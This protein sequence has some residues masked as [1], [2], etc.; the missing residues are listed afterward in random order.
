ML[1]TNLKANTEKSTRLK[2]LIEDLGQAAEKEDVTEITQYD[3]T[4]SDAMVEAAKPVKFKKWTKDSSKRPE[5]YD[6]NYIEIVP[7][8]S[9]QELVISQIKAAEKEQM[10][11]WRQLEL[12]AS[13]LNKELERV[14]VEGGESLKV[15]GLIK[16]LEEKQKQQYLSWQK[17]NKDLKK[18]LDE[19]IRRDQE[20]KKHYERV[21]K[22]HLAKSTNMLTFAQQEQKN[23]IKEQLTLL[24]KS[25]DIAQRNHDQETVKQISLSILRVEEGLRTLEGGKSAVPVSETVEER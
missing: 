2:H 20:M 11:V 3:T 14:K 1:Q 21:E 8:L 25:L 5:Q 23:E 24:S 4:P 12:E 18:R 16:E 15:M 22:T 13:K 10:L 6:P 7:E 19:S 9:P 17:A